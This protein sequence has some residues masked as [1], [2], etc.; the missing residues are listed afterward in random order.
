MTVMAAKRRDTI[1]IAGH[2]VALS[3]EDKVLYPAASVTKR[4]VI[5]YYSAIAPVMLPHVADRPITRKRWPNGVGEA[6]FFE[7]S[8]R[9]GVPGWVRRQTL[10]HSDRDVTYP[11]ADTPATLVWL[12]QLAA[13]ELHV[14]QWTLGPRGGRHDPD[15]LVIDLDPGPGAG[16]A[17]C[18]R[19]AL[20][21]RDTLG[22]FGPHLVP[23]TS[24]SKGLHLYLGLNGS[25]TSARASDWAR[26]LA[27]TVRRAMPELV[28]TRMAR[29]A[30]PGKVFIDWSQNNAAKTT[31]APYSLRG[32]ERPTVATP[33]RWDE[34]DDPDLGQLDFREV[35]DRLDDDGDPMAGLGRAASAGLGG[36]GASAARGGTGPDRLATYRGKRRAGRTPEPIPEPTGEPVG[37]DGDAA[38]TAG[39]DGAVA[40]ARFVVQEHHARRL[41]WDFRLERDG[42]LVSWAVPKGVPGAGEGNHLAVQTEDHPLEYGSFAGTLP[43]GQYGAG[44]VEIWDSGRY[45]A[46]K[47]TDDEVIAVLDGSR[48]AGR[49]ALIRTGG[50]QWLLRYM[51]DQTGAAG[52]LDGA[53]P[54]AAQVTDEAADGHGDRQADGTPTPA[55]SGGADLPRD[56]APMLATLGSLDD[57]AEIS[58][59][60]WQLEGKWDGVRVV[61]EWDGERLRAH[62]RT[63]RDV[64]ATYPELQELTDALGEHH[65]VLDG[66]MV[67]LDQSGAPS[68]SLLQSR[69]GLTRARDVRA[70]AARMPARL[71]AFDLLFLNGVILVDKPLRDRRKLL[72]RLDIDTEHCSVPDLLRGSPSEALAEADRRHLEGI[73]A[74]RA[75]SR[76]RPGDRPGSWVKVKFRATQDV[77]VVG[78]RPGKG[79]RAGGIG[80]LLVAL[81]DP[82]GSG[83]VYAGR[84]G[85][86]MTDADRARLRKLLAPLTRKTSP[87]ADT[88]PAADARDAVWVRPSLVGEVTYAEMTQEKRLRQASWRGLRQDMPPEQVC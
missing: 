76:Y 18:V 88:V 35:L 39:A 81:H 52:A 20:R 57:L 2:R 75:S 64:T 87:V 25:M 48:A 4:D 41:H 8:L 13:L 33:R 37:S 63:G 46:E 23:V 44:T 38:D 71:F 53:A 54:P 72:E 84:V 34:L 43:Q 74:K 51:N 26:Q 9:A 66:E 31:I 10:R 16:L 1:E 80:S 21:I 11:V 68:F 42:V 28:V 17:D 62:S 86:G 49:Y 85:T 27:E 61:V 32:R 7:K 12:A 70:A 55:A 14:P 79:Q 69:M 47:W 6:P 15:R 3:N 29:S 40:A 36:A 65:A 67:A 82:D 22:R 78:W 83:L 58:G 30:R 73:V 56:I 77:V 50:D 60:A 24:G 5:D 19:V 59:G 45:V